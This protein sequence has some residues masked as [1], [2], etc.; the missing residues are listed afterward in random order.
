MSSLSAIS[1]DKDVITPGY[2]CPLSLV[3][4]LQACTHTHTHTHTA[5]VRVHLTLSSFHATG[6]WSFFVLV[7]QLKHNIENNQ[8]GS[9]DVQQD[10]K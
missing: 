9:E 6:C 8:T 2:S 4:W 7:D 10:R 1:K 3:Y 5:Y